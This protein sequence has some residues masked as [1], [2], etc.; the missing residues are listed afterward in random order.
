[1]ERP[2]RKLHLLKSNQLVKLLLKTRPVQMVENQLLI[3]NQLLPHQEALFGYPNQPTQRDL[4][5]PLLNNQ[6]QFYQLP[7]LL[8]NH[9]TILPMVEINT[10]LLS[11]HPL[12][13]RPFTQPLN[14]LLMVDQLP[15]FKY[16]L[17]TELRPSL[18]N[19]LP[20]Q[21]ERLSLTS[22]KS[23]QT[24][25]VKPLENTLTPPKIMA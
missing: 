8:S 4:P 15:K 5:V 13:P 14:T 21:L 10:P 11:N 2:T 18:R 24:E 19:T 17:L 12:E 3:R 6:P 16:Q 7:K 22:M 25:E 23:L 1:M 20:P 9:L